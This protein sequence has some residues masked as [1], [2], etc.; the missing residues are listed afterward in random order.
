[1]VCRLGFFQDRRYYQIFCVL[2]VFFKLVGSYKMA[3]RL[4]HN[5]PGP[6][7]CENAWDRSATSQQ[8]N[9]PEKGRLWRSRA[10]EPIVSRGQRLSF[11]RSESLAS[12]FSDLHGK[13]SLTKTNGQLGGGQL[14]GNQGI[15]PLFGDVAQGQIN[16]F[17]P[18]S[19]PQPK[20]R[21]HKFPR[22]P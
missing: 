21:P 9:G 19:A 14:P 3:P 11:W 13:E 15:F 5:R 2:V 8:R 4:I 10:L 22:Q 18:V 20:G 16:P 17:M 12:C 7:G 1:M 6:G